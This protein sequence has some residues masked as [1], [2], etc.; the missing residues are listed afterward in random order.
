MMKYISSESIDSDS[1]DDCLYAKDES[2][3]SEILFDS[4]KQDVYCL[5]FSRRMCWI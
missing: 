3:S 5:C 1:G 4:Y 2:Y